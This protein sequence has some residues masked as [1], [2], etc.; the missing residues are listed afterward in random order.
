MVHMVQTSSNFYGDH[1]DQNP[2]IAV[3]HG[4]LAQLA[5]PPEEE[6]LA[7]LQG[8]LADLGPEAFFFDTDPMVFFGDGYNGARFW[9]FLTLW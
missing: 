9:M 8:L 3:R 6:I 7:D 2:W 4:Q 5:P 1:G